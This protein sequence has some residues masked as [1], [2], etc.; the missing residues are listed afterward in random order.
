MEGYLGCWS[1]VR[2]ILEIQ[3]IKEVI[4]EQEKSYRKAVHDVT[5]K[6]NYQEYNRY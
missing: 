3:T 1:H 4:G 2:T 6:V 5:S